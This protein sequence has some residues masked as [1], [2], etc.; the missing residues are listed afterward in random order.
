VS[1]IPKYIT[2][3]QLEV[4]RSVLSEGGYS[5]EVWA[6]SPPNSEAQAL[7]RLVQDGMVD[8]IDLA[9]ELEARFGNDNER[10]PA[11]QRSLDQLADHG[12]L[13]EAG[14]ATPTNTGADK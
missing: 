13:V 4:I 1:D 11:L 6:T 5:D 12:L 10:S 3:L 14:V 7:I 9:R 8:P 2:T